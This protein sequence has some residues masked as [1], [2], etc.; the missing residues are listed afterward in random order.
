MKALRSALY[1]GTVEHQRLRPRRH[2]LSYDV[3]YLLLDLD[4][5]EELARASWL[6]RLGRLGLFSFNARDHGDG[7][8]T[9]LKLQVERHLFAAGIVS[10]GGPIRLLTLPR[11][12]GYAFNPI[13]VYF[14]HR[15]G[16]ALA[17]VLYEVTNTFGDRHSY[18]IPV[19][20]TATP[21]LQ[22]S[23][24]A[25]HVS[26]FLD[27]DM[28]YTFRLVPPDARIGLAV[29]GLDDHG[30]VIVATL[31][32]TRRALTDGA[33][34][35]VLL[36][37]PLMTLKVIAAIHWEALRLWRK[38]LALHPRPA[39]PLRPVTVGRPLQPTT[40]SGQEEHD[41]AA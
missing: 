29:T 7:S 20:S 41:V 17:A 24:K 34:L 8:D 3:F 22:Q 2:H 4:E 1:A 21:I 33:L 14:C 38:G 30:P 10:D 31:E 23:R 35:R 25:L 11:I 19:D 37:Y 5:V 39:P 16:G 9:A 32:A 13:S 40:D 15:R 36:A 28:H 27:N 18:L 12:L 26:P 6:F